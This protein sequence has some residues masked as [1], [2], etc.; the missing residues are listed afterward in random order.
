MSRI[1]KL[2]I[3]IPEKVKVAVEGA[4]VRVEGPK[5]KL[6]VDVHPRMKVAVEDGA[7]RVQRPD[8]ER[9]SR[10]LHGLTRTLLNN[11]VRGVTQG[12]EDVLEISGVG[13][14]AE[15]KGRELTLAVGFSHPVSFTLPEGVSCEVDKQTRII[16]RGVDKHLV[17]MTASQIRAI[18][19][20]EP[21]KGKGIKYAGE[22][23]RRKVGKQAAA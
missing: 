17:G 20:T 5:G 21:Y 22:R 16:L 2:P 14:R 1:G 4:R 12:F 6:E 10:R 13:Y 11:A 23:V 8:D 15:V 3:P 9:L 19:K 18:R 7:L